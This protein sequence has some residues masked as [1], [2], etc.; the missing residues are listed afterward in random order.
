LAPPIWLN[1]Y[2][3]YRG[4]VAV[5]AIAVAAGPAGPTTVSAAAVTSAAASTATAT[6]AIFTRACNVDSQ[7]SAAVILAVEHGDG[8]LGFLRRG[9]LD[10]AESL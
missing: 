4:L 5:S 10:E 9:H 2:A 3:S 6:R 7:W 1:L 8:A